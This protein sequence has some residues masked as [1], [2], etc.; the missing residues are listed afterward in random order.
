MKKVI[1][2]SLL[3]VCGIALSTI[4]AQ[5]KYFTRTGNI[6]FYSSAPLE[7]IEAHNSSASSVFDLETGQIQFAVLIKA[8]KFKKAL[9]EEHFNENYM[10]SD[11]FPKSTF[12][13]HINNVKEIDLTTDG[14][15]T[16]DVSG[17]LTIHGVSKEVTTTGKFTVA[18]GNITAASEF[19]VAVADY[20]IVIPK[21]VRD[22]IAK[23]VKITVDLTYELL[24]K[25]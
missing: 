15:Y 11:D 2:L 6:S 3:M 1:F 8:F 4:H 23:I 13:G 9:M 25:S 18:D 14:E 7:D 24:D 10:E 17:T 20:D 19:E 12:K 22:N 16:A 21:L 5:S